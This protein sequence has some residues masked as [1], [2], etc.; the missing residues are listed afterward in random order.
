MSDENEGSPS[1]LEDRLM[2]L[3]HRYSNARGCVPAV[4]VSL[5]FATNGWLRERGIAATGPDVLPAATCRLGL[6]IDPH[7]SDPRCMLVFETLAGGPAA[8][9][10]IVKGDKLRRVGGRRITKDLDLRLALNGKQ[11]GEAIEVEVGRGPI[12]RTLSVKL[13]PPPE[14]AAPLMLGST[15]WQLQ[16]G[17]MA[18]RPRPLERSFFGL[19][20]AEAV[21]RAEEGIG[22][23][24]ELARA[25]REEEKTA[26]GK[27]AQE[28]AKSARGAH[29]ETMSEIQHGIEQH[30][31]GLEVCKCGAP[32]HE[33]T[34]QVQLFPS[35]IGDTLPL[36]HPNGCRDYKPASEG[37]ATR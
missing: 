31:R 9:A 10:G 1:S 20:L 36:A 15:A 35:E 18:G 22:E 30:L 26:F 37:G 23:L 3:A 11:P 19:T 13:G 8:T 28:A 21:Y 2:A 29:P 25:A 17:P 12:T 27:F 24:A 34:F 7:E 4:H 6:S 32:A 16:L 5:G 14:D 33:H